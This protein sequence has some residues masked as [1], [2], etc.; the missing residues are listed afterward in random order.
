MITSIVVDHLCKKFRDD[1]GVGIAYIY[2]NFRR[3]QDQQVIDLLSSLLKQ[4]IQRQSSIP[5]GVTKLYKDHERDRTR[6]SVDE[7]T[8]ILYLVIAGY[9]KAFIIIDALDEVSTSNEV[10]SKFLAELFNLQVEPGLS[11]FTTSRPILGIP[12]EF[13][14]R[15]SSILEIRASDDDMDRYLNGHI[16]QILPFVRETE[17]IEERIKRTII[18]AADGMY[19]YPFTC[20]YFKEDTVINRLT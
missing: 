7:I 1:I 10:L 12:N 15:G 19:V 6:P 13:R 14:R 5:E 17:D 8:S 18:K 2:C 4:F 20:N 16:S 9:S 3:Q 11:L